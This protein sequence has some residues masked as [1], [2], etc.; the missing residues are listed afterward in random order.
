MPSGHSIPAFCGLWSQDAE[1][2]LESMGLQMHEDLVRTTG[3]VGSEAITPAV[4]KCRVCNQIMQDIPGGQFW[5]DHGQKQ[6]MANVR[7]R[8]F[9]FSMFDTINPMIFGEANKNGARRDATVRN[10][11]FFDSRVEPWPLVSYC[12]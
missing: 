1:S 10:R 3:E 2:M 8:R 12:T 7:T 6:S 9:R 4:R 11:A 5:K